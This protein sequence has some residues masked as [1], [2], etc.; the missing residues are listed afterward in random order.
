MVWGMGYGYGT[1]DYIIVYWFFFLR[2]ECECECVGWFF[3]TWCDRTCRPFNCFCMRVLWLCMKWASTRIWARSSCRERRIERERNVSNEIIH[4]VICDTMQAIEMHIEHR[5]RDITCGYF[6]LH[7]RVIAAHNFM[8]LSDHNSQQIAHQSKSNYWLFHSIDV[9][10]N[11]KLD[12]FQIW[13]LLQISSAS[14]L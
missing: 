10:A 14:I 11:T 9:D 1:I 3:H 7:V 8:I 2:A 6:A 4:L 13:N 12:H 5:T